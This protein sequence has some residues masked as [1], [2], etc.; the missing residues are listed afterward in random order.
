MIVFTGTPHDM[1]MLLMVD[2]A[3]QGAVWCLENE[4]G[5]KKAVLIGYKQYMELV[6]TAEQELP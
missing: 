3:M 1:E 5:T 6:A 4:A 2:A